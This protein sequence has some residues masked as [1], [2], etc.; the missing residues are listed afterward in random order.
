MPGTDW[1]PPEKEPPYTDNASSAGSSISGYDESNLSDFSTPG[2]DEG[3]EIEQQAAQ[4]ARSL[5]P[6][7]QSG[8]LPYLAGLFT[9][10]ARVILRPIIGQAPDNLKPAQQ[11][12]LL[13]SSASQSARSSDRE[14][15]QKFSDRV[16]SLL[17]QVSPLERIRFLATSAKAV[18]NDDFQRSIE[19]LDKAYQEARQLPSSQGKQKLIDDVTSSMPR[20]EAFAMA[21]I[22]GYN[23]PASPLIRGKEYQLLVSVQKETPGGL[24][25]I[26]EQLSRGDA[27][28]LEVRIRVDGMEVLPRQI[29]TATFFQGQ[30][31]EPL[32]FKL[33]PQEAGHKRIEIE[34]YY[35]RHWLTYLKLDV[36]TV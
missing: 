22:T 27:V 36:D 7:Y 26:P 4:K 35:Q 3:V 21:E 8:I 2:E 20:M 16:S 14:Q 32:E 24:V 19:L 9:G 28:D 29:R 1:E 17:P 10:G 23:R 30:D 13:L 12:E 11:L 34:F 33:I 15:W 18:V 31:T 25:A 6:A 5:E